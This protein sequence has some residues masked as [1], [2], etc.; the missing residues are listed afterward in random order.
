MVHFSKGC[1]SKLCDGGTQAERESIEVWF[2]GFFPLAFSKFR[3][4]V[5]EAEQGSSVLP[6]CSGVN[7]FLFEI[8]TGWEHQ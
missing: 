4:F 7:W 6:V 3:K 1:R 2:C 8:F 5:S